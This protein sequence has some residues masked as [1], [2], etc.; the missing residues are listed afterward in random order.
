MKK[1]KEVITKYPQ[2][3][4]V[5][6][7]CFILL[8]GI[9]QYWIGFNYVLTLTPII[10]GVMAALVILFWGIDH[11]QLLKISLLALSIGMVTE[12]IG[13][14]SG[15]LFGDYSYSQSSL[16]LRIFG[17]P[18]L[19][20]IMWILVTA[21]AWQISLLGGFSGWLTVFLASWVVVIFDIL[22]EQYATAYGLWYWTNGSIPIKNYVTWFLVS[23]IIFSIFKI[24][25]KK[26]NISIY[27]VMILPI[28]M[29]YFWLMLIFT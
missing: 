5:F 20:G 6:V 29:V 17:V 4:S 8:A 10:I 16:G 9:I 24:T 27:G 15:L 18:L 26:N 7:T 19:V 14:N 13:V 21:S 25:I 11:K 3:F 1:I 23:F 2:Q 12:I 28:M 22:L